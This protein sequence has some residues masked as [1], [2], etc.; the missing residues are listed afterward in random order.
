M[1]L[2]SDTIQKT[3][4]RPLPGLEGAVHNPGYPLRRWL[5]PPVP[6]QGLHSS[7]PSLPH[8]LG[9]PSASTHSSCSSH[10][11]PPPRLSAPY[12]SLGG[13]GQAGARPLLVR[14]AQK[15]SQRSCAHCCRFR[16]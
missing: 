16:P 13:G 3:L 10:R 4:Q 2:L 1:Q 7:A 6:K 8:R 11:Q 5:K 14:L 15:E 12:K 9:S